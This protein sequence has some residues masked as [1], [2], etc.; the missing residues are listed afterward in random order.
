M[1]GWSTVDTG[2]CD[3]GA[4]VAV[5]SAVDVVARI[6]STA[7]APCIHAADRCTGVAMTVPTSTNA[8]SPRAVAP[9]D[10]HTAGGR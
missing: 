5:T 1:G 6:T 7:T 4:A 8:R 10:D 9:V 3:A 2:R